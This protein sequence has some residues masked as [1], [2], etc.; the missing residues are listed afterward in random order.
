M[1]FRPGNG[2]AELKLLVGR[3]LRFDLIALRSREGGGRIEASS[4]VSGLFVRSGTSSRPQE[5]GSRRR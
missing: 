5:A 4:R 3:S 2:A 1:L